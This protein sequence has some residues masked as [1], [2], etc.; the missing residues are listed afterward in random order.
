[1]LNGFAVDDSRAWKLVPFS[2]DLGVPGAL[3]DNFRI[4]GGASFFQTAVRGEYVMLYF[5][6]DDR[7]PALKVLSRTDM[8]PV[9]YQWRRMPRTMGHDSSS[10]IAGDNDIFLL[11]RISDDQGQGLYQM[12]PFEESHL[13]RRDRRLA[14]SFAFDWSY[15]PVATAAASGRDASITVCTP[16]FGF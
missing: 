7:G 12:V 8:Q 1:M 3:P 10:L 16:R 5:A 2:F 15:W 6:S 4:L 11:G 14:D 13:D 9:D